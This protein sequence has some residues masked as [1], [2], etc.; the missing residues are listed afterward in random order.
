MA[1]IEKA[2]AKKKRTDPRTKLP[3]VYRDWLDVFDREQADK[4][5]PHRGPGVDHAIKLIPDK[6]GNQPELPWG[7]SFAMSQRGIKLVPEEDA[8]TEYLDKG[9]I[10][11]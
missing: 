5:P 7:P 11:C 3:E 8:A 1:D 2:L 9:L 6:N 4:L 10:R